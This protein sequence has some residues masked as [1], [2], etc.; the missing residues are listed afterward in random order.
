MLP[1]KK[2]NAL[3]GIVGGIVVNIISGVISSQG[4][5]MATVG[6]LVGLVGAVMFIWGCINLAVGKGYSWAFGL[7]AFLPCIGLI[8]LLVMPD[9]TTA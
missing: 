3:I 2:N 9:K 5:S 1:E 4:G 6:T 8:I 7:L